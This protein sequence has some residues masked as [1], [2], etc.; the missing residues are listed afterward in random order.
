MGQTREREAITFSPEH[1]LKA[2]R[3]EPLIAA[4]TEQHGGLND[5]DQ[6]R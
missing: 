6:D 4:L 1:I 3:K 2:E 5:D